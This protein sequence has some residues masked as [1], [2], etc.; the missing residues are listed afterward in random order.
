MS[1]PIIVT[2][3]GPTRAHLLA[4]THKRTCAVKNNQILVPAEPVI[5]RVKLDVV[6]CTFISPRLHRNNLLA[7]WNSYEFNNLF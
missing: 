5:G 2:S 7:T 6:Y 1:F 4:I 3:S